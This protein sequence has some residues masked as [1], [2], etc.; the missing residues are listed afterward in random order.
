M[1]DLTFLGRQE[2]HT[3]LFWRTKHEEIT[4]KIARDRRILLKLP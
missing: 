1:I 3:K 4:W 2:I